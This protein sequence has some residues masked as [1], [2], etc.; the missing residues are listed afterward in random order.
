MRMTTI[1]WTAA[2]ALSTGCI[3]LPPLPFGEGDT[4]GETSDTS[5]TADGHDD[6]DDGS[7]DD[8]QLE[9]QSDADCNDWCGWCDSDGVCQEDVG[10]CGAHGDEHNV[11][12]CSPPAECWDTGCPEGQICL[13]WEGCVPDPDAQVR[14]PA[15]CDDALAFEVDQHPLDVPVRQVSL[16]AGSPEQPGGVL[17][18]DEDLQL[19]QIDAAT[20]E[21]TPIVTAPGEL[22]LDLRPAD[23]FT[24]MVLTE[25]FVDKG[26]R[27]QLST[28]RQQAD[29][30]AL[31][32]GPVVVGRAVDTIVRPDIGEALVAT[33]DRLDR[34]AL[35]PSPSPL[36]ELPVGVVPPEAL[37][38]VQA[39]AGQDLRLAVV[40]QVG[41]LSMI[42]ADSAE[43]VL[44]PVPLRG[45]GVGV[46][47]LRDAS[48]PDRHQVV[49]LSTLQADGG[50]VG[51]PFAALEVLRDVEGTQLDEAF[52]APGQPLMMVVADL[53][54]NGDDD[55]VVAMDDGRL[56]IYRMHETDV[57]CRSYV[58]LSTPAT[59]LEVGDVNGDG[60]LDVLVAEADSGLTV[61]YAHTGR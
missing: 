36:G 58:P 12:R 29:A 13:D 28:V 52:G 42:D 27:Y 35:D 54:G 43:P 33:P 38:A 25:T 46:D 47:R 11:W 30:W 22:V 37:V 18:L 39:G 15:M 19:W 48:D 59:D 14:Q 56:D 50:V 24:T 41:S 17:G 51:D 26:E 6:G 45:L 16:H 8:G 23:A 7:G 1:G 3:T 10:C 9:C 32:E 44:D 5:F 57:L 4:D 34:W 31:Q 55:V 40:H 20:G 61:L 53:D 2:L 49:A 21:A 60:A